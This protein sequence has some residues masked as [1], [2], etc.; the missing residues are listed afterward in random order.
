MSDYLWDKTGEPDAEVER[1]EALLGGLAHT[2]RPLG[3]PAADMTGATGARRPSRL[4]TPARLAAAAAL[5]VA[6]LAGAAAL[7]RSGAAAEGKGVVA[8]P[9]RW[10][11]AARGAA[12][13]EPKRMLEEP[14]KGGVKDERAAVGSFR[15]A[16]PARKEVQ[17]ASLPGRRQ[18]QKS[19]A[20]ARVVT[21]GGGGNGGG[22]T[23]MSTPG[24]APSLF[25]STRLLAKEQLVYALRLTG[26]K[27][28]DVSLKTRGRD[29]KEAKRP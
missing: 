29:E 20:S 6:S 4:W 2:P 8:A 5:A 18:R 1:F 26:S 11:P 7:L 24:G 17:L 27:L 12:K 22:L 19:A 9:V 15:P 10:E 21:P 28:R 25:D 16:P 14:P 3:L 13:D 23:L